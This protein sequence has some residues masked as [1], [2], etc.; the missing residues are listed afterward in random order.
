MR[1]SIF[2][3]L[4]TVAAATF[5]ATAW[6]QRGTGEQTGVARQATRPEVVEVTGTLEAIN[7]GPCE[8]TT[9]RAATGAHLVVATASG[10]KLNLHLGP[11]DAV[12]D[13]LSSLVVGDAVVAKAF[14]TPKLGTD[15]YVAQSVE[16][17]GKI[18]ALRDATLRPEWAAGAGYGRSGKQ[19]K[20]MGR[21]GRGAGGGRGCRGGCYRANAAAGANSVDP[22]YGQTLGRGPGRGYGRG[23]A[24]Q[25]A[26]QPTDSQQTYGYGRGNGRGPGRG[27][28]R[29]QGR[30]GRW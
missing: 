22:A 26:S 13:L 30:G 24:S 2:T 25:V 15:E 27:P 10:E 1:T 23:Q 3:T 17:G 16:A 6:A 9:G 29:G 21:G 8:R 5:A 18:V 11:A 19:G 28:G 7:I 14:Q 12:R 20:G 4:V